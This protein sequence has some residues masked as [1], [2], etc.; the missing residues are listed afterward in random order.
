MDVAANT[1]DI[2]RIFAASRL[3]T[4]GRPYAVISLPLDQLRPATT[5]FGRLAEPFTAMIVDKDEITIVMHEMDWA[6]RNG[7]L[8]D[9]RVESNY[10]L[11][12]FDLPLALDVVGFMAVV[13]RLLADAGIP[14][15]PIAAYSRDHIFIRGQDVERA[16]QT[17]SGFIDACR[18][19]SESG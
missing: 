7:G 9:V 5:L 3:H 17:L 2:R 12:T 8:T 13:S 19:S 18:S 10:R 16:W 4:D 14:I 11:I 6:L 1:P 15:V